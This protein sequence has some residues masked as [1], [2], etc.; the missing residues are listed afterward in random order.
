M[1]EQPYMPNDERRLY[2]DL[3][4]LWPVMS[5]P[6]EYADEAGYWLRELRS[7]LPAGRRRVLELGTG[8][9]HFLHQLVP[10]YDAVAVDPSEAMLAHSRR[11]NPGVT[12][13]VGDMRTVRLGET[14]DAV[15]I[16]D[17]ISYMLTEEDLRAA[18]TTARAHLEPGGLLIVAP[19]HYADTFTSPYVDDDTKSDGETTL[20]YVEYSVVLDPHGTTVET[21]YTYYIARDGE[22]RVEMDRHTTGLFPL[23]TWARVLSA[24]GFGVER[25]DYPVGEDGAP[26][27]LWVGT[28]RA[29]DAPP[30]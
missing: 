13:Y 30:S 14:F 1:E 28:L 20:T 16:H 9:G 4:W 2:G 15:L 27:Y 18:F 7:R 17:A 11:L 21:V 29:G 3:A 19:D 5:P 12:H 26:M 22:L 6:E 8:G 24:A 23:A 10:E 25:V